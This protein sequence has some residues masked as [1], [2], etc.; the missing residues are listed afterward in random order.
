MKSFKPYS[1]NNTTSVHCSSSLNRPANKRHWMSWKLIFRLCL[2]AHVHSLSYLKLQCRQDGVFA[3]QWKKIRTSRHSNDIPMTIRMAFLPTYSSQGNETSRPSATGSFADLPPILAYLAP[4]FHQL[5][6]QMSKASC[7]QHIGDH[8]LSWIIMIYLYD[9]IWLHFTVLL[10][11][12]KTVLTPS[13]CIYVP[14]N[15]SRRMRIWWRL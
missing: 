2:H 3:S 5:M 9:W 1:T 10:Q 15:L 7:Q 11:L 14:F 8:N 4:R 6:R 12:V 13:W